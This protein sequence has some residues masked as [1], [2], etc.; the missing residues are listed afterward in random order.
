[1]DVKNQRTS[2]F[3]SCIQRRKHWIWN[4]LSSERLS[5]ENRGVNPIQSDAESSFQ[6]VFVDRSL[7][8]IP[9]AFMEICFQP[10]GMCLTYSGCDSTCGI[11]RYC[12]GKQFSSVFEQLV[13]DLSDF[14]ERFWILSDCLKNSWDKNTKAILVDAK[15]SPWP[16]GLWGL[17]ARRGVEL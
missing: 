7:I 2:G 12:S 1:M 8:L 4:L 11:D 3:C 15:M 5:L 10:G 6:P 16:H 9:E 14:G 17:E 13:L